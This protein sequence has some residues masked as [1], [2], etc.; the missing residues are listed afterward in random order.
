M[1]II[2]AIKERYSDYY[3]ANYNPVEPTEQKLIVKLWEYQGSKIKLKLA[4]A[5]LNNCTADTE[6]FLKAGYSPDG[7]IA[8][9]APGTGI[10]THSSLLQ[11]A[12][13]NN[14][15]DIIKLLVNY[16][17][18]HH[19]NK[20]HYL[21]E[22][23][24]SDNLFYLATENNNPELIE[25]LADV[26]HSE[27]TLK[28][29]FINEDSLIQLA[30]RLKHTETL[31]P[32]LKA[33]ARPKEDIINNA[34]RMGHDTKILDLLIEYGANVNYIN[35]WGNAIS[36]T[37]RDCKEDYIKY[38]SQHSAKV[39]FTDPLSNKTPLEI[40]TKN[41]KTN[42]EILE[43]LTPKA[44]WLHKAIQEGNYIEA[45]TRL[46]SGECEA[47]SQKDEQSMFP[48]QYCIPLGD[49]PGELIATNLECALKIA[50]ELQ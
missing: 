32:L 28:P 8:R 36:N 4:N 33:G 29:N 27:Y 37:A 45:I 43:I 39:D 15:L 10:T 42:D 47:V 17:A 23:L 24:R 22:Y 11:V 44:N 31:M 30:I 14:N 50:D 7:L 13:E 19:I 49:C 34:I 3:N 48:A 12:A 26:M 5:V 46:K 16:G 21:Y 40:Y 20:D 2:D 1:F 25:Y 18:K 35:I 41:C 9:K 6:F 38:L